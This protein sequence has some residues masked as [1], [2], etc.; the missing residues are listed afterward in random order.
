MLSAKLLVGPENPSGML[1]PHPAAPTGTRKTRFAFY[2]TAGV[3]GKPGGV[4][5]Q[6]GFSFRLADY[7]PT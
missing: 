7:T 4:A 2:Y 6:F 5:V 1:R 3:N